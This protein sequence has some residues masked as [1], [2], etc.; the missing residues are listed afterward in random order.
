MKKYR[1]MSSATK[2]IDLSRLAIII[3]GKQSRKQTTYERK[4]HI[5]S[6]TAATRQHV[7][8]VF[9]T[10]GNSRATAGVR[11]TV[12]KD[13][14]SRATA[15]VRETVT[16]DGNSRATAGVRETVTKDG[17][18]RATAGV[19]ETV[20]KDGFK[21]NM[22]KL[23]QEYSRNIKNISCHMF[24]ITQTRKTGSMAAH[25]LCREFVLQRTG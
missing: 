7:Q 11:E 10:H 24:N 2:V 13:G 9:C 17:N 25:R 18:S 5:K 23:K 14:N 4:K 6:I 12:T 1:Q 22:K 21:S 8:S 19:R 20:T 3:N 16:K 15:G